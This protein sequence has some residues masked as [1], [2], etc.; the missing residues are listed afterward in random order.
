MTGSSSLLTPSATLSILSPGKP[1]NLS[2]VEWKQ[3]YYRPWGKQINGANLIALLEACL[4]NG[5]GC[6]GRALGQ[7]PWEA[8]DIALQQA[9]IVRPRFHSPWFPS[10]ESWPGRPGFKGWVRWQAC[11][12]Q[13]LGLILKVLVLAEVELQKRASP[14]SKWQERAPC[15]K[16]HLT[17]LLCNDFS[18]W[19]TSDWE[20]KKSKLDVT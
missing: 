8:K 14:L 2:P 4:P 15:R 9:D 18:L 11:K 1:K 7:S 16:P 13:S 19:A 10:P 5:V 12:M 20:G 6:V 3:T 17:P